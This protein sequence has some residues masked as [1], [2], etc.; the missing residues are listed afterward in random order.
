MNEKWFALSVKETESKLKTNAATGLS[1]KVA[2]SRALRSNSR[3]FYTKTKKPYRMLIDILSD[4]ALILLLITAASSIIFDEGHS[5][6]MVLVL[7]VISI[8][9]SFLYYYRSQRTMESMNTLFRPTAKVIRGG[10]LYRI[11]IDSLVVGDVILLE[12]GDVVGCDARIVTSDSLSVMMRVD[13][14]KYELL[15]KNA[16][17]ALNDNENNPKNMKNV[18]HAGS[19]IETGSARAIAVA[20]GRYTYIGARTGGISEPYND[21]VPAELKKLRGYCSKINMFSMICILPFC[22]MS[23]L[24]GHLADGDL[25][26]STA[27]LTALAI[28]VS[29][30]S[31]LVCTHFK[32]FFVYRIKKL[33]YSD[34]SV[35]IR[36]T[37]A[38]DG[39]V[40]MRYL[41]LLDGASLTDGIL[42]FDR[43]FTAEGEIRNYNTV[44]ATGK[45]LFEYALMYRNSDSRMLTV[46]TREPD[47]FS[48]GLDEFLSLYNLDSASVNIRRP[49]SSYVVGNS[50]GDSDKVF[51]SEEGV[52]KILSV[53]HTSSIIS[54]CSCVNVGGQIKPLNSTGIDKIK[55]AWNRYVT[56]G[57]KV[58]I[59]TVTGRDDGE[60][61]C[62]IGMIALR[63]ETNAETIK[64]LEFIKRLNVKPISFV[65][66][67]AVPAIPVEAQV[68]DVAYKEDFL[69]EGVPL[70]YKFGEI[71]T[72]YGFD[73]EDIR[74][75]I[76]FAHSKGESVGVIGF[77]D[78]A[79]SVIQKS[80][81]FISCSD[82][83]FNKNKKFY[84]ELK[85]LEV[86]GTGASKSCVQTVKSE[87]DVLIQRPSAVGGGLISLANA[88]TQSIIACRNLSAFFRYLIGAWLSRICIA[89]LPMMLG[90]HTLD[91]RHLLLFGFILD[92]FVLHM[93]A[94]DETNLPSKFK[95]DNYRIKTLK[96]TVASNI[97]FIISVV[98]SSLSAIIVPKL[99][100]LIE[101]F[102]RFECMIEYSFIATVWIHIAML[103]YVRYG[104]TLKTSKILKNKYFMGIFIGA[105]VFS[106]LVIWENGIGAWF[107][108]R[109]IPIQY[110]A[111]SVVHTLIFILCVSIFKLTEK[112]DT[113]RY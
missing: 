22:M 61:R 73:E 48:K 41:F 3:I 26:L 31:Q 28:T 104:V 16:E 23:L 18:L 50:K 74:T 85:T 107:G 30:M 19:V 66:N 17:C 72:Y 97:G 51:F 79:P 6:V 40:D 47:R 112:K 98:I 92:F 70:T 75:L 95:A 100:G 53:S 64:S 25:T 65:S 1:R 105:V 8:I 88:I 27:F 59:F 2:R 20:T 106:V 32:F 67:A 89:A 44:T 68:G 94:A 34:A 111:M 86:A 52:G 110:L 45:E 49:I 71:S 14:N 10:K 109:R 38:F 4:F 39:L 76:D 101:P 13:L 84:E 99:V 5:P 60:S 113:A 91:A 43:A 77:S 36:T 56:K 54:K 103:Y 29:A 102:G 82:I 15:E 83:S 35:A 21:N 69:R 11:D 57:K 81:V 7:S 108:F 55:H 96:E 80:N 63:E 24:F 93:F 58:L 33:L 37:G 12:R 87:A 62:F 9:V 46:G 42:H 90:Y 78:Y